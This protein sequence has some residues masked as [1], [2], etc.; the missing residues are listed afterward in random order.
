MK[1][2]VLFFVLLLVVLL[3]G[4]YY[5]NSKKENTKANIKFISGPAKA[6]IASPLDMLTFLLN[7][8]GFIC[9]G[10]PHPNL[11]NNSIKKPIGSICFRGFNVTLPWFLGV[12][13]PNLSAAKACANSWNVIAIITAGR[14]NINPINLDGWYM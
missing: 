13:S 14:A 11:V 10:F 12:S 2:S 9:T 4:Y 3:G 6:T 7:L 8:V 1:K 5:M